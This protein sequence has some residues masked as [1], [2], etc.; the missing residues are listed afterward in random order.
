MLFICFFS[1]FFIARS[2]SSVGRSSETL[3]RDRKLVQLYNV[4]PHIWGPSPKKF[5]GQKC[6]KLGSTLDNFKLRSPERIEISK[7]ANTNASTTI[8]P[9]FAEKSPANF[10]PLTTKFWMCILT[11]PNQLFRKTTFRPLCG[12][13]DSFLYTR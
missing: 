13:G 7:I 4:G 9:A 10:G 8:F 3:P 5:G 12:A 6:A 1:F 11:H 2:P